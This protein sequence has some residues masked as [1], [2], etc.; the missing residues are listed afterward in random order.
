LDGIQKDG[1]STSNRK[2]A[3]KPKIIVTSDGSNDGFIGDA[4][5]DAYIELSIR[6]TINERFEVNYLWL[7]S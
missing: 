6:N 7:F 2:Y 4:N 5:N 1:V 3:R